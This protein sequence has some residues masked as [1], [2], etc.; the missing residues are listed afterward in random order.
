M[1][2]PAAQRNWMQALLSLTAV[3][4]CS[5]GCGEGGTSSDGDPTQLAL[6]AR[7]SQVYNSNCIA[8]HN[9]DP[10]RAGGL[11]PAIAGST[12]E[13]VI[14]KVL[15]NQYPPG[16][17][18]KRETQVMIPMPHLEADIDAIVAFLGKRG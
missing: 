13:L 2:G 9:P 12:R 1:F 5:G 16:Y 6:S 11:G 18:P 17:H 4:L 10:T 7:G 8:C 3:L 14:G 15:R